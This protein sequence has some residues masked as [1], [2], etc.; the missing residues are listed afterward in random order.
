MSVPIRLIQRDRRI[1]NL[2]CTDFSFSLTRGVGAQP[3]P[4]LGERY[5]I[6]MNVVSADIRLN[7]LLV[8]DDCNASDFQAT[9]AQAILDFGLINTNNNTIQSFFT[10]ADALNGKQFGIVT[11]FQKESG[12]PGIYLKFKSSTASHSAT[13]STLTI[14]VSGVTTAAGLATAVNAAMTSHSGTFGTDI[15]SADQS[16]RNTF[17]GAFTVAI[18]TSENSV[19]GSAKI[20]LTQKDT[21]IN[22]NTPLEI[23]SDSSLTA[24]SKFRF[25][26][27]KNGKG[28][29]C[30]SAGDKMQDLIANVANSNV[31]GAIGQIFNVE[32]D[33][34]GGVDVTTKFDLKNATQDYIVGLQI[35]YNSLLQSSDSTTGYA[36]RNFLIVTGLTQPKFQNAEG[37]TLD[38]ANTQ[39]DLENMMTGI[40]GTVTQCNFSYEGGEVVY[41]AELTFSPLDMILGA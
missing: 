23:W 30:R 28:Q 1:I 9:G 20:R 27:F 3:I 5:G 25:E 4:V 2:D 10:D 13:G 36:I 31:M 11:A 18:E 22:G 17:A 33:E 38:G 16:P 21:G 40:R 26:N 6:D 8:D 39:F 15:A 24:V 19:A 12:S 7:C 32:G 37:N 41:S 14:G 29:S 34:E 35:P